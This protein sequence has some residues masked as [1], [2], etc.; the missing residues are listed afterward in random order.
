M[1]FFTKSKKECPICLQ[2]K[3]LTT[4]CKICTDT[5]IC[6]DCSLS[7]CEQGLCGKC[8]VCRQPNWKQPK[9]TQILPKIILTFKSKQEE[10]EEIIPEINIEKK[11][12]FDTYIQV[13][14]TI[15]TIMYILVACILIYVLGMFTIFLFSSGVDWSQNGELYWLSAIVGLAWV[16]LIWSPCCC[17]KTLHNVYCTSSTY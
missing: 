9:K 6:Q 10:K 7:L 3:K 13:K 16:A 8:P 2:E 12:C 4:K 1:C 15:F 5:K 17:G 11:D 14:S